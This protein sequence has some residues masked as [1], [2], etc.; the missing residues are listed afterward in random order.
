[1]DSTKQGQSSSSA[2]RQDPDG[3]RFTRSFAAAQD[4]GDNRQPWIQ[5]E[6]NKRQQSEPTNGLT[7]VS[8]E[9][10]CKADLL[11]K[12]FGAW[13]MWLGFLSEPSE[14]RHW[15]RPIGISSTFDDA[16]RTFE[17]AGA[18]KIRLP[19][20]FMHDLQT[21][22]NWCIECQQA[23]H[24]NPDWRRQNSRMRHNKAQE[25]LR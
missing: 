21:L 22:H 8:T 19:K 1:M 13:W 10:L 12:A 23:F 20:E 5:E 24:K 17:M 7:M 14:W 9:D 11:K 2:S 16:I 3:K 15:H 25:L 6:E 4:A 18:C